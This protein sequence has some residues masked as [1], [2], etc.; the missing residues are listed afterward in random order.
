MTNWFEHSL[1]NAWSESYTRFMSNFGSPIHG[2]YSN[3]VSGT[4]NDFVDPLVNYF[5]VSVPHAWSTAYTKFMG[6]FVSPIHSAYSTFVSGT[7]N[8]FVDPI[9]NFFTVSLPNGFRTA[10][11]AIGNAWNGIKNAMLEAP[12]KDLV[13]DTVYDNGTPQVLGRGGRACRACQSATE[14]V[15]RGW[16]C[17]PSL[18]EVQVETTTSRSG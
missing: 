7:R 5:T 10:V 15:L 9:V 8:D 3:V 11:S 1:P 16:W 14:S 4:L 18:V 17:Q 12:I 13:I 6:N 2:A